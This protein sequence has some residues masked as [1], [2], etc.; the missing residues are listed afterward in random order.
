V[1]S[2]AAATPSAARAATAAETVSVIRC[3][4]LTITKHSSPS[5]VKGRSPKCWRTLTSSSEDHSAVEK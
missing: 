2:G 5:S 3:I 1:L 4:P